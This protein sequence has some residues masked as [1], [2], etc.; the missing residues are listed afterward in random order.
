MM[1]PSHYSSPSSQSAT[2]KIRAIELAC[3]ICSQ[4][5]QI[6]LGDQDFLG[7]NGDQ[8]VR[9]AVIHDDHVVSVT[10]DREGR[11]RRKSGIPLVDSKR[12]KEEFNMT[13]MELLAHI[14]SQSLVRKE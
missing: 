2:F 4:V 8:L 1:S 3:P 14:S 6:T 13:L 11:V 9:R 7:K 10:I 5:L 12:L